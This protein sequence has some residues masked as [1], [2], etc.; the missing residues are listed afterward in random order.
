SQ[1][2]PMI[3]RIF[4]ASAR[5]SAIIVAPAVLPGAIA[6][7]NAYTTPADRLTT[8]PSTADNAPWKP[9]QAPAIAA[10]ITVAAAC[11]TSTARKGL[12]E[13]GAATVRQPANAPISGARQP[14]TQ[15]PRV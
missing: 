9:T 8:P 3:T 12:V 5:N 6:S 11:Q 4:A 14:A 1:S 7:T 10:M 15:S 13:S 2:W